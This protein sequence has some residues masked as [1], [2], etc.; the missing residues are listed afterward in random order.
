MSFKWPKRTFVFSCALSLDLGL[1][2]DW[3]STL[4]RVLSFCFIFHI[5]FELRHRYGPYEHP[6]PPHVVLSVFTNS[7][8]IRNRHHSHH[9]R[10]DKIISNGTLK[11]VGLG[12]RVRRVRMGCIRPVKSGRNARSSCVY[13]MEW[14]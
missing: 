11:T 9:H 1:R 4:T 8:I 13:A 10:Y 14:I 2:D 6:H 12:P 3:E 5:S 7:F